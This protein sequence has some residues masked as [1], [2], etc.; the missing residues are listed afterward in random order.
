MAQ[1]GGAGPFEQRDSTGKD[2][3]GQQSTKNYKHFCLGRMKMGEAD[4]RWKWGLE[5]S[6]Q[7]VLGYLS[8]AQSRHLVNGLIIGASLFFWGHR[9]I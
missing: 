5:A 1:G 7:K 2:K 9:P 8:L 6:S 4:T 3:R